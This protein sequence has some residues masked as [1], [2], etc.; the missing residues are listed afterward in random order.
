MNGSFD[1][2]YSTSRD[3]GETWSEARI[4]PNSFGS[5]DATWPGF[6]QFMGDFISVTPDPDPT[7][8]TAWVA[9]PAT[10]DGDLDIYVQRIE[11]GPEIFLDGFES[12]DVTRWSNSLP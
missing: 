6:E 12:G 5:A 10:F 4:T 2:Y 11:A 3:R 7:N 9:Y 8:E 1:V